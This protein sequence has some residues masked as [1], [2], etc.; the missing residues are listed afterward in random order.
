[1]GMGTAAPAGSRTTVD[2]LNAEQQRTSALRD[3]AQ[4][5]Y[6]YLVSR[7]RLQSLAGYDRWATID[8]ANVNLTAS[9]I[10]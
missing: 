3:L 1:M 2:V 4:A 7:V 5:R 8:Q 10:K 6:M 9:Q